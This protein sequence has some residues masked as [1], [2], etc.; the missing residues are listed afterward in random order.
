MRLDEIYIGHFKNLRDLRVDFD[1][2]SPYTVLVG[3]NGAGKS[4]LLEALSLI[5][6]QLDLGR[7]APFDYRLRYH[8]RNQEIRIEASADDRPAVEARAVGQ[9]DYRRLS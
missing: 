3:E 6:R 2:E 1:E 4:N 8:C 9:A 5:F 7:P